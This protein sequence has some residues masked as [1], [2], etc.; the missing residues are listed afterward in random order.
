MVLN[1][2][3]SDAGHT[4][5]AVSTAGDRPVAATCCRGAG[6]GR[7]AAVPAPS[8]HVM[9]LCCAAQTAGPEEAQRALGQ[10]H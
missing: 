7:H 3:V 10:H 1:P 9:S 6:T 8:G 5:H 4:G 2:A